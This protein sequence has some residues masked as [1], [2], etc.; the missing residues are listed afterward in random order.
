M[1]LWILWMVGASY[2]VYQPPA[3]LSK[4]IVRT[5]GHGWVLMDLSEREVQW[6]ERQGIPVSPNLE[7]RL[8][9]TPSD[10]YYREYQWN[11][12]VVGME[13]AWDVTLGDASVRVGLVDQGVD[14]LHPDLRVDG[15]IDLV[16]GDRDV[17]PASVEEFHGSHVAGIIIGAHNGRGLAGVAPG[18][19]LY[20]VRAFSAATASLDVIVEG[21]YWLV[22]SAA[23]HVINLS[24]GLAED[25]AVLDSAVRYAVERGVIVVAAAGNEG[26]SGVN[27]PARYEPVIAVGAM[28]SLH[29]RAGFSNWGPEIDVVAPGTGI[30]SAGGCDANGCYILPADGT[31]MATPHVTGLVALYLSQ[32]PGATLQEV[33]RAIRRATVDLHTPGFDE[34]TGY[35]LVDAAR[36]LAPPVRLVGTAREPRTVVGWRALQSLTHREKVVYDRQGRRVFVGRGM[37]RLAPGVYTLRVAGEP[38]MYL[39]IP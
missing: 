17:R 9:Y 36:L 24:L 25:V 39:V 34:E 10:P 38:A 5:V 26:R 27:Y 18:V 15:G 22:D 11:L 12:W 7:V 19:Q 4:R 29:F 16:D 6:L 31:S 14:Y 3:A 8:A 21:I 20:A 23:V 33:L 35:G 32:R 30:W 13:Q 1:T 28:D 2:L 37:P